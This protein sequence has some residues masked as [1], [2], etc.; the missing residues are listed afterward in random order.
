[1]SHETCIIKNSIHALSLLFLASSSHIFVLTET[2]R[3]LTLRALSFY[4]KSL[5]F[6][7]YFTLVA[8]LRV[9]IN[10]TPFTPMLYS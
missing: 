5:A 10:N 2:L 9:L 6:F 3:H 7:H 1:M 8:L 4:L